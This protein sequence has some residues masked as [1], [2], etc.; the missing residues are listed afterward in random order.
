MNRRRIIIIIFAALLLSGGY[1]WL[2]RSAWLGIRVDVVRVV[3]GD[4]IKV[5]FRGE[6]INVRLLG[7]DC[8]ESRHTKK[9]AKQAA[10]NGLTAEQVKAIG[11]RATEAV[12]NATQAPAVVRLVFPRAIIKKDYFRR[13]LAYVEVDGVDV[14]LM[15]IESGLADLYKTNHQR[16]AKYRKAFIESGGLRAVN[17][18]PNAPVASK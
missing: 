8:F 17:H 11:K 18:Q 9:Q 16:R 1:A 13:L 10:E 14:G 5:N 3:D 12:Q 6:I 4:T 15:L 7:I 2:T